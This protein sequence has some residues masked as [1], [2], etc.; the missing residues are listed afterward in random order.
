MKLEDIIKTFPKHEAALSEIFRN[1]KYLGHDY[2][3]VS[4]FSQFL[5]ILDELLHE[6]QKVEMYLK[7][8][9]EFDPNSVN[10]I[11]SN[12]RYPLV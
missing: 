8:R 1:H 12:V 11:T 7:I 2:R 4:H 3:Y 6:R 10:D 9:A 5:T